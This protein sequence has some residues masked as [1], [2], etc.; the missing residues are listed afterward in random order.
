MPQTFEDF[1]ALT[2]EEF[3]QMAAFFTRPDED[4]YGTVMQ[5]S[6]EYD[7]MTMYLYPFMFS[8]GGDIWNPKTREV[9][10][11]LNSEEN[12]KGMEWNKRFCSTSRRARSASVSLKSRVFTQNKVFSAFQWALSVWQ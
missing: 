3:E 6:K 10:G 4:L 8:L 12:A 9:W 5:Y 1:E 7:F 2:F 11:V